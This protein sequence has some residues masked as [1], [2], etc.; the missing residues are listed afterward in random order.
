M[1][2]RIASI[3]RDDVVCADRIIGNIAFFLMKNLYTRLGRKRSLIALMPTCI[4]INE[5]QRLVPFPREF[6]S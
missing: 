1:A 4:Y 2:L 3:N 6:R 5:Q